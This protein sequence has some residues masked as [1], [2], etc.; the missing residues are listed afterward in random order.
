[1]KH[2]RILALVV[3]LA[4]CALSRSGYLA[5]LLIVIGL[6]ALP[7]IGLAL[8]AGYTG[9]ISLGH[10][11]FYGLG[12]YGAALIGKWLGVPAWLDVLL[13]TAVGCHHC[14]GDRLARVP[15]QGPLPRDGD[16]GVRNYRAGRLRRVARRDRRTERA[17]RYCA[18]DAFRPCARRRFHLPAGGL[19]RDDRDHHLRG[20]S[21]R[22]ADG[23]CHAGDLPKTRGRRGRSATMSSRSSAW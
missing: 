5:S 3:L 19:D 21:D 1:M 6:Q 9:Q 12:A 2:L 22:V 8:I 18:A 15:P 17:H 13:A 7:A 23:A 4:L 11:A 16:A 14:L 20:K 10:A